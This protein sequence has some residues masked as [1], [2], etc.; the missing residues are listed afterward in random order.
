M[1]GPVC[2]SRRAAVFLGELQRVDGHGSPAVERLER[3]REQVREELPQLVRVALNRRQIGGQRHCHRHVAALH[4]TLGHANRVAD[5]VG[6]RDVL[7]LQA[8]R[9]HEIEHLEHDG[10][11]HLRFFDDV[12]EDRLRVLGVG[13]LPLQQAG[14]DFDAGERI[15]DLV[16]NRGGHLAERREPIAQPLALFELLDARQVLEEECRAGQ[17]TAQV[18]YLRQRV[19]DHLAGALQPELGAV[20]QVRQLERPRHD[21][22]QFR[23]VLEDAGK[24]LAD[25]GRPGFEPENAVCDLVHDRDPAVARHCEDAVPEVPDEVAVE[26]VRGQ[27]V[28]LGGGLPRRGPA[29]GGPR[30]PARGAACFRHRFG[31]LWADASPR[32]AGAI[33]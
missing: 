17:L 2:P 25:V 22:R 16:R 1:E 10:V 20:G 15:L 29:S 18:A 32:V 4:M 14:H 9:P 28:H 12:A 31:W 21:S 27:R 26:D 24:R 5:D 7:D 13:E 6:E 30:G 23:L 19:A 11:R 3:V 33:L 8:D